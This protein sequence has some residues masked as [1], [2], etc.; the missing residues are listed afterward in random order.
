MACSY[1]IQDSIYLGKLSLQ[2][3]CKRTNFLATFFVQYLLQFFRNVCCGCRCKPVSCTQNSL[4][5]IPM[6]NG[7]K[8]ALLAI[9]RVSSL[10]T[11]HK[12]GSARKD[13]WQVAF[14]FKHGPNCFSC[15]YMDGRNFIVPYI[16]KIYVC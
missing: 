15:L 12:T 16:I 5:K 8:E 4:D 10:A 11:I 13:G 7:Y 3:S 2:I 6:Q 14:S 1:V 9:K